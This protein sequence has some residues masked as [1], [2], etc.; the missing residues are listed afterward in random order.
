M[1]QENLSGLP[2]CLATIIFFSVAAGAQEDVTDSDTNE[3]TPSIDEKTKGMQKYD[4]FLP[5]YWDEK[6][7]SVFSRN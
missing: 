6:T 4:G 3:Q 1:R 7:G 2:A 5:F